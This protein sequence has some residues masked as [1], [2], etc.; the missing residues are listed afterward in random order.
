[1]NILRIAVLHSAALP[2][3]SHGAGW[4]QLLH[5]ACRIAGVEARR[6]WALRVWRPRRHLHQAWDQRLAKNEIESLT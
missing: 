2:Q 6:G 5:A 3:G 4:I 1:M